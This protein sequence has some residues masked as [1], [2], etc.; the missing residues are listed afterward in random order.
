MS[1]KARDLRGGIPELLGLRTRA[2]DA[3]LGDPPKGVNPPNNLVLSREWENEVP[4][5]IPEKADWGI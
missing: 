2:W 3:V 5:I 4:Y 1:P